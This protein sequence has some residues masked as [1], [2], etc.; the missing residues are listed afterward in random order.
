MCIS[1]NCA[2]FQTK[3]TDGEGG[4]YV[5]ILPRQ[6]PTYNFRNNTTRRQIVVILKELGPNTY[7]C[8]RDSPS[9]NDEPIDD[10][11]EDDRRELPDASPDIPMREAGAEEGHAGDEDLLSEDS[12]EELED[13]T[14]AEVTKYLRMLR[15]ANLRYLD[16]VDKDNLPGV[17]HFLP[18]VYVGEHCREVNKAHREWKLER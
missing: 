6:T 18:G 14:M 16:S 4:G 1:L 15:T 5:N 3:A 12:D 17:K 10:V 7:A 2:R 8:L 11:D 13:G 9:I